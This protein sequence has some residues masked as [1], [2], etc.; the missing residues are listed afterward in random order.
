[1]V[2]GAEKYALET[3]SFESESRYAFLHQSAMVS[4]RP[5]RRY[6]YVSWHVRRQVWCIQRRGWHVQHT[7]KCQHTAAK[8]AAQAFGLQVQDLDLRRLRAAKAKSQ[9]LPKRSKY[10]HVVW[11]ARRYSWY[12]QTSNKFYGSFA[13]EEL[14][15]K[16]LV[17]ASCASS[18]HELRRCKPLH[19]GKPRLTL[20]GPPKTQRWTL[21]S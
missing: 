20:Q 10:L 21:N 2:V 12:A 3:N 7:S 14:A 15:A 19:R 9:V 13:T 17:H 1:M 16:A 18:L 5:M 4:A 8:F 6:K 11:H